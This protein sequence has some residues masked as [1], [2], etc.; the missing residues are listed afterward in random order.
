MMRIDLMGNL[1]VFFTTLLVVISGSDLD[2]G[3][4][5]LAVLYSMQV[6]RILNSFVA[7]ALDIESSA[8]SVT[9]VIS[10]PNHE[11]EG[12]WTE[13]REI[14][15][16]KKWPNNGSIDFVD[17]TGNYSDVIG[18]INCNILFASKIQA[19]IWC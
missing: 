9:R 18:S 12:K 2:I 7:A 11:S 4:A 3:L 13:D 17:Y 14:R 5:G 16:P 19:R 10:Y 6:A 15:L 8:E 1:C